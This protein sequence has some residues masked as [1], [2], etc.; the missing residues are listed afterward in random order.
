[1]LL[2]V[3]GLCLVLS[4]WFLPCLFPLICR[5][6]IAPYL[7]LLCLGFCFLGPAH[8]VLP[9]SGEF[10]GVT[11]L[12]WFCSHW[13]PLLY[14]C[15]SLG[16]LDPALPACRFS[17]WI[18]GPAWVLPAWI[19]YSPRSL[20]PGIFWL[21]FSGWV[22]PGSCLPGRMGLATFILGG[23]CLGGSLPWS[24]WNTTVTGSACCLPLPAACL[25]DSCRSP[26]PGWVPAL[27]GCLDACVS[28]C[29]PACLPPASLRFLPACSH[30]HLG[31]CTLPHLPFLGSACLLY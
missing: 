10:V 13:V 9:F 7:T 30:L 18:S 22:L 26:A 31:G 15:R 5:F 6:W 2:F 19:F 27:P 21:R 4:V 17:A 28:G 20:P 3:A 11:C 24:A 1:M 12:S 29:L 23:R 8:W 16:L 25:P 14:L